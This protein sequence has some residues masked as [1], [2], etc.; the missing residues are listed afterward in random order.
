MH[1]LSPHSNRT[2]TA[3]P[4]P[5]FDRALIAK[6]DQ[7]GPR[8]TSYPTA[9]NFRRSISAAEYREI[10]AT[11]SPNTPLSLYLHIPFCKTRCF[12]C[13][14][15]VAISR[16]PDRGARYLDTLLQ[17]IDGVVDALGS[18]SSVTQIHW[19]G[20]TPTFLD[21]NELLR[22]GQHLRQSF[23]WTPGYEFG[24]EIDPR[25]VT[26]AQLDALVQAGVNRLSL[27]VQD[28]DP[29]V[30]EA[31][32]RVQPTEQVLSVIDASRARGV[33][34]INIDLIYG[35]PQQTAD[36][37]VQTLSDVKRLDPDR[38]AL[39]NFAFLPSEIPHQRAID[40]ASL[41]SPS[42]KLAI[43][44]L[45]IA[46]LSEYGYEFIGL[47][48]FAKRDDSLARAYREG[49]LT[50]NFQ[51]YSTCAGSD[52]IGLGNSAIGRVGNTFV[53]NAKEIVDYRQRI[54]GE[55]FAAVRGFE[56]SAEDL[57]RSDVI[58]SLLCNLRVDK[59]AIERDHLISFDRHFKTAT[60]R[61]APM[62]DDGLV[63]NHE[64][65]LQITQRGRMMLRN[66]AMAFDAYL[67]QPTG[68][69]YSRTV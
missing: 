62:V 16:N 68:A 25:R 12:F 38:I 24:V 18:N 57:L 7:P 60:E 31:I 51:G 53:Q 29:R 17:E 21:P 39:F 41:P 34:S 42:E 58:T 65:L 47:D 66:A 28:V 49:T 55:N 14:C 30:Q 11:R 20:G 54:E 59:R 45:A 1:E 69:T 27:G 63:E 3:G 32:N 61:L 26:E 15:Q 10:L 44:E 2:Q 40:P 4:P 6:Y 9:P 13:G 64:D 36:S 19:G 52:L 67:S 33:S 5:L 37:F 46:T 23:D 56:L 8:Y 22:L 48:H 50:R 35:L 43:L